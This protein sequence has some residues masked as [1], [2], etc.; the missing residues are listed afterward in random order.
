M[1]RKQSFIIKQEPEDSMDFSEIFPM[2]HHF[3]FSSLA[4]ND[5]FG[6]EPM[7]SI[8]TRAESN[9]PALWSIEKN[10]IDDEYPD[11]VPPNKT[12][13]DFDVTKEEVMEK[14]IPPP[15]LLPHDVMVRAEEMKEQERIY[16]EH[17]IESMLNKYPVDN[18]YHANKARKYS[19]DQDTSSDD[20]SRRQRTKARK[21]NNDK[22]MESRHRKKQ[23]RAVNAYTMLHLR[24]R[25]L[26]YQT[27][28]NFM[29]EMLL[30]TNSFDEQSDDLSSV[31]ESD[32]ESLSSI[33][34]Y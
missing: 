34:S 12:L 5:T 22:S 17:F 1:P 29:K 27:R 7:E 24:E 10:I 31:D 6:M 20:A 13:A 25:I 16:H 19:P 11:G 15:R 18:S 2:V 32:M 23:E 3:S 14:F 28:M 30:Q 33:S 21:S 4:S 9:V 26:E 8:S